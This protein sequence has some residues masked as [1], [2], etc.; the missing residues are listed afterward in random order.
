MHAK[1]IFFQS[2]F[3]ACAID[4]AKTE[5][6]HIVYHDEC[7]HGLYALLTVVCKRMFC[8][9]FIPVYAFMIL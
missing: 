3:L 6:L 9:G 1:I 2:F 5:R 7:N 4:F 8:K